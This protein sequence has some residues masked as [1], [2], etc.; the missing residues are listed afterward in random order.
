MYDNEIE[1]NAVRVL[2]DIPD[3]QLGALRAVCAARGISQAEAVRLAL[4][5]FIEQSRPSREKAFGI[6]KNQAVCLS[7][8]AEPLPADGL[9]YQEKLRSEWRGR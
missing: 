6:W 1:D 9:A 4:A 2:K 7:G 5:A 3:G 8:E